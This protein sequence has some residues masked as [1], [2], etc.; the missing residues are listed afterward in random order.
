MEGLFMVPVTGLE[1]VWIAPPHFECG[2]SAY[3]ATPANFFRCGNV[4][5]IPIYPPNVKQ[6][7]IFFLKNNKECLCRRYKP[8][9]KTPVSNLPP[10]NNIALPERHLHTNQICQD[11]CFSVA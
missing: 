9:L 1:P 11:G 6:S 7:G 5:I 4:F 2:A 8:H 3:S 10:R